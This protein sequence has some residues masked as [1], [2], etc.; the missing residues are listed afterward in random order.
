MFYIICITLYKLYDTIKA[1]EDLVRYMR[2]EPNTELRPKKVQNINMQR[3]SL[4]S[5]GNANTIFWCDWIITWDVLYTICPTLYTLYENIERD[6]MF[7]K[8]QTKENINGGGKPN[9]FIKEALKDLVRNMC[10]ETNTELGPKK[11]YEMFDQLNAAV[12][13]W[14]GQNIKE[15]QKEKLIENILKTPGM[16]NINEEIFPKDKDMVIRTEYLKK[17][18]R[19]KIQEEE[20]FEAIQ[21]HSYLV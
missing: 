9:F 7:S 17:I 8:I 12:L 4:N 20:T 6:E 18:L 11:I 10:G 14:N 15:M 16:R 19:M 3:W 13:E 1:L 5:I 21:G 2:G